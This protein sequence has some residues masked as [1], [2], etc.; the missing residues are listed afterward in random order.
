MSNGDGHGRDGDAG[1]LLRWG[2]LIVLM[3]LGGLLLAA[4]AA[5]DYTLVVGFLLSGFAVLLAIRLI[6]R[7]TPA[8]AP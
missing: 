6:V 5:D 8:G 1:M 7:V 3:A 2:F 4:R